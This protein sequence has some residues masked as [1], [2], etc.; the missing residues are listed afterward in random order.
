MLWSL[1]VAFAR[2]ELRVMNERIGGK[3][4]SFLAIALLNTV[5][6]VS[7]DSWAQASVSTLGKSVVQVSTVWSATGVKAGGHI[8]LAVVL[9]IQ[10]P[11]HIGSDT[12]KEPFIPTPTTDR[13]LPRLQATVGKR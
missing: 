12:A 1:K 13:D 8:N 11:Y 5:L 3:F 7:T 9:E 10:T 2:L 6:I 4:L